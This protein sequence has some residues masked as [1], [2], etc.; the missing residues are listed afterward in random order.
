[1]RSRPSIYYSSVPNPASATARGCIFEWEKSAQ[2][3]HTFIHP[4][5][6]WAFLRCNISQRLVMNANTS[7][8]W[9]LLIGK[10]ELNYV[11]KEIKWNCAILR[12]RIAWRLYLQSGVVK[13]MK[14]I[15]PRAKTVLVA[16]WY[17]KCTKIFTRSFRKYGRFAVAKIAFWNKS[18][19]AQCKRNAILILFITV[20]RPIRSSVNVD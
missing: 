10:C 9:E 2:V 8:G 6:S 19:P 16:E 3:L 14:I 4:V 15:P 17:L 7:C 18:V 1:M 20:F 11:D 5:D 13:K 12:W